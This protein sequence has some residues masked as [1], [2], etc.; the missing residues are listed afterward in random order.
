MRKYPLIGG[1]ILVVVLLMGSLTHVVGF[2]SLQTSK[3]ETIS[4]ETN[5]T[6]DHLPREKTIYRLC[7]IQSGDVRHGR[8]EGW[9]IG[10]PTDHPR[11]GFCHFGIGS[12]ILTLQRDYWTGEN[13]TT[14]EITNELFT[15]VFND[16]NITLRVNLFIGFYQPT[17]DL[18][19]GALSGNAMRVKIL[20]T[21]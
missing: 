7:H 9:F 17:G 8:Y 10:T 4:F 19:V 18:G 6:I 15:K 20:D 2:Q 1:S 16:N 13:E 5:N 3:S 12:F 21:S 14:L 11:F